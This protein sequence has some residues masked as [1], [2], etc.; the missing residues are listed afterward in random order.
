MSN[1]I[2]IAR[3]GFSKSPI[4][5]K[6]WLAA[7]RRCNELI[8]EEK[9]DI[10]GKSYQK[11]SLKTDSKAECR[12]D[13]DGMV[14]AEIPS[15]ELIVVMFKLAEILKAGIYS[16]SLR[17]FKTVHDCERRARKYRRREHW[18]QAKIQDIKRAYLGSSG[19]KRT[20]DNNVDILIVVVIIFVSI[21]VLYFISNFDGT[22]LPSKKR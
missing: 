6:E 19:S 12:L 13:K 4:Q 7:V 17:K 14:R 3:E 2:H 21:G 18:F 1:Y 22:L 20:I 16:D 5:T 9:K 10:L 15:K 8:V 11:V